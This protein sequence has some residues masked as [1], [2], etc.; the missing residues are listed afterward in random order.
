[1]TIQT[2]RAPFSLSLEHVPW[3]ERN[4]NSL[5]APAL[6]LCGWCAVPGSDLLVCKARFTKVQVSA[7]PM[8]AHKNYPE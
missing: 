1:M 8:F 4:K 2:Q 6:R 7:L 5:G 3:V